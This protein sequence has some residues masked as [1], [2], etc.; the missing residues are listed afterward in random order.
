MRISELSRRSGVAVGTIK[1]YLREGLLPP[2]ELTSPTQARYGEEHLERL[3]LIR[4][5]VVGG[6]LSLASV[7]RMVGLIDDPPP[8][9]NEIFGELQELLTPAATADPEPA[10][11]LVRQWG[12]YR[13]D[14]MDRTAS[15]LSAALAD[16]RDAGFVIPEGIL[17]RYAA[18]MRSVAELEI[19][20]TPG[21]S[22]SEALRYTVLGSV[23]ME[24]VLLAIRRL[25]EADAAV[26]ARGTEGS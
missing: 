23:L 2:G 15:A 4:A 21:G 5:L 17:E 8:D 9:V 11:E 12:W 26:R 1:F 6:G 13:G 25:A 18:A 3:L 19:A 14:G 7:H 22:L 16:A 10:W 20:R 24:P